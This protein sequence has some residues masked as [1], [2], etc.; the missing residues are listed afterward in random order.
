ML[1]VVQFPISDARPFANAATARL[2]VPDW[3]DPR[4]YGSPQFVRRFGPAVARRRGPDSAWFDERFYCSAR[5]AVSFQ[6]LRQTRLD[7]GGRH[8]APE[9]TFRRLFCDDSRSVVRVE[10]GI[11]V[12]RGAGMKDLEEVAV[13]PLIRDVLAIDTQVFDHHI[14]DRD[15]SDLNRGMVNAKLIAQGQRLSRLYAFAT[16]RRG[17]GDIS[18]AETQLVQF[19]LPTVIAEFSEGELPRFPAGVTKVDGV[20]AGDTTLGFLNLRT[21]WGPVPIWLLR[22]GGTPE[23]ALR[24]LR[25]CLLRLHAERESLNLVIG[26]MASERLKFQPGTDA[27]D[28]LERYLDGATQL[29]QRARTNAVQQS[30]IVAA[31]SASEKVQTAF[32]TDAL[33]GRLTG[34]RRQIRIKVERYADER[35][36]SRTVSQ[37][38]IERGGVFVQ[39]GVYAP[40]G[41][42]Y[43]TVVGKVIAGQI[44]DSFNTVANSQA[45]NETKDAISAL[46]SAVEEL[47]PKLDGDGDASKVARTFETLAKEVAEADPVE[48][49]VRAAGETLIHIGTKVAEFAKP[50]SV[51]VNGVLLALKFAPIF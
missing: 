26:H 5:R 14:L 33:A 7:I 11:R 10:V 40:E 31:M 2:D 48:G 44:S 50:I 17:G 3:P 16:S 38:T 47:V 18:K 45:S 51:A 42:F 43:G 28:R 46:K 19:G 30:Q 37:V 23:Q 1:V 32:A 13:I 29:V 9:C 8:V 6:D 20:I 15:P 22:R 12:Q 34:V 27:G 49:I 21:V 35:G 36:A 39:D 25:L 41:N 24:S 4:T